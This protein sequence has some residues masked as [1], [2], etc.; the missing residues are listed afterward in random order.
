M[1]K[2]DTVTGASAWNRCAMGF[3]LLL[4]AS[5]VMW[6]VGCGDS[7]GTSR[8][9]AEDKAL[10]DQVSKAA[11]D[12]QD[13]AKEIGSSVEASR[14]AISDAAKRLDSASQSISTETM[15]QLDA[16]HARLMAVA[17]Q[18]KR[19]ADSL[20]PGVDEGR[21]VFADAAT[22]ISSVAAAMAKEASSMRELGASLNDAMKRL[23]EAAAALATGPAMRAKRSA[24]LA[25]Q[26]ATSGRLS[27]AI[28]LATNA[29]MTDPGNSVYAVRLGELAI[30]DPAATAESV[31]AAA[32]TLRAL[33]MQSSGESVLSVWRSA[34]LLDARAAEL[35][36]AA[37]RRDSELA[38]RE[39]SQVREEACRQM[40]RLSGEDFLKA[41]DR[42]R[43]DMVQGLMA[44][45]EEAGDQ[46]PAAVDNALESLARWQR[47]ARFDE[48]LKEAQRALKYVEAEQQAGRGSAT[49]ASA[50]LASA[51]SALRT[52]WSGSEIEV[53]PERWSRA[54]ALQDQFVSAA[55]K[56]LEARDAALRPQMAQRVRQALADAAGVRQRLG[57]AA[58]RSQ[59]AYQ[60]AISRVQDVMMAVSK[61]AAKLG[62][63]SAI[64][65]AGNYQL[66]LQKE[67]R[68]LSEAQYKSMCTHVSG[69]IKAQLDAFAAERVVTEEDALRIV[70]PLYAIDPAGLPG[71]LAE[72]YA[73]LLRL[74]ERECGPK[75]QFAIDK[76]RMDRTKIAVTDF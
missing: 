3:T 58:P 67:L 75:A 72:T 28:L 21:K 38:V 37:A 13:T 39:A 33:A 57:S 70:E 17:D 27:D 44:A 31:S 2:S 40:A 56:L 65:E 61:D 74:L 36:A 43:A 4:S 76:A 16:Q 23:D 60:E 18:L 73:R 47:I 14:V 52:L 54:S 48:A 12:V 51:E 5:M 30:K 64:A 50:V 42:A 62:S 46:C 9:A 8:Q 7:G 49:A 53:G 45:M 63:A 55:G 34:D 71:A 35:L 41:P 69:V 22:Q 25:D 59:R 32:T 6:L 20:G 66:E 29:A 1:D 10:R 15:K 26:A 11:S 68:Q 24:E 19:S